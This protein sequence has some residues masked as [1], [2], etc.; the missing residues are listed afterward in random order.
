MFNLIYV[1]CCVLGSN[2]DSDILMKENLNLED[3]ITP[4]NAQVL[5]ELLL[6]SG[7]DDKKTEF[8]FRGFSEGFNLNYKGSLT[9]AR[10][11]APNLKIRVGS[12]E[13]LWN[14]IM[15]EVDLGRF[16]G[17]FEEP[18]F[19]HFVQSPIGL[20]PKDKG[21]KTRLIFH[22]SYPRN[23]ESVNL[24]IPK[25]K[26]TV[27]YPDFEQAI[28]RCVQ[29]GVGCYL[30][31]SDMS[32]AFRHVP[33]KKDQWYLLVMKARHPISHKL[34]YFVDKCLPFG[35]SISCAIFQAISDA[36]A[37]IVQKRTGKENVNYLDDYLFAAALK[38]FCDAQVEVFL[39]ICKQINFPVAL[40]KTY[41]GSTVLI[42][43]GLLLDTERQI[44]CIP[45]D[46]VQ[47]ALREIEHFLSKRKATV[48]QFQ[49]LCG[50]LNFLCRCLLPGKAFLRRLYLT[51]NCKN[52]KQ[53]HHVR[54]TQENKCDLKTW[55][56]FLEQPDNYYRGFIQPNITQATELDIFSDASRNFDLGFGAY[57]GPE[58]SHG[59]W[60]KEFCVRKQPSIEYLELYAVAV[61]VLNWLKLFRNMKIV[62]FCDN[63]AVVNMINNSSSKCKNCMIL[64]RM[65][66][67]ESLTCNTRVYAKFV[68]TKQN[69]KAD[70]LSRGQFKRFWK[71][72]KESMNEV[73][74]PLPPQ[75][76]VMKQIWL[77]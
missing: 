48:L 9:K 57:C 51:G 37:F 14:K 44:V 19:E 3:I 56:Y 5:K 32:S 36:I 33:M 71:L 20:V 61:A 24:G 12:K 29:E 39:Q 22:L 43:L 49:K 63:Q 11:L 58:W 42:F 21:T 45:L 30:A 47:K 74:T 7:Y 59:N 75:L 4:V 53:H 66:V 76:V 2:K 15:K 6:S 77:D 52:L 25:E 72:A 41:W 54:I 69:G 26:C 10:R 67:L 40:E 28:Q 38:A 50:S 68:P 46:K 13:E 31:K 64:I 16:A 62:L 17:P 27:K 34:F 18:P 35:S 55:K 23:G 73:P 65:I 70:A 60:D 8:L 1:Y